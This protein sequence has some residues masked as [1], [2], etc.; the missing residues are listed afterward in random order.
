MQVIAPS[1]PLEVE[2]ATRWCAAQESGPVY[3]RLGKAGEQD[4]TS[5]S[6]EPWKFGKIRKILNGSE[7]A[8]ISYGPIIK[9]AS[10]LALELKKLGKSVALFSA[11]TIKP[12]D[13]KT[14]SEILQ[15]FKDVVIIEETSPFGGL[16]DRFKT[17]AWDMESRSK[18]MSFA[19]KDEF[20][21]CYGSHDDILDAHGLSLKN[22]YNAV[23]G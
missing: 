7:I 9:R 5:N 16:S 23:V 22:I 15:T 2:A 12:F 10:E 14:A 17:L 21:K 4:F 20:I 19:L 1:D 8:V 3:L 6:Q 18:I 13:A 11:S